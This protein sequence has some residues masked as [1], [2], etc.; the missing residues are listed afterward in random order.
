LASFLR[1]IPIL[2]GLEFLR[3]RRCCPNSDGKVICDYNV[4]Q[5]LGKFNEMVAQDS[6]VPKKADRK[7][8]EVTKPVS[9]SDDDIY[10]ITK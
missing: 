1:R 10:L 5:R 9:A 7:H 2:S 4:Y 3:L 8:A 6:S